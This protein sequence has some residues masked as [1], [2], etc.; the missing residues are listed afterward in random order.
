[1]EKQEDGSRVLLIILPLSDIFKRKKMKRKGGAAMTGKTK[2]FWLLMAVLFS[3]AAIASCLYAFVNGSIFVRPDG[4]PQQTVDRFFDALRAGEYER[5][6]GCLE[7]ASSLGLEQAVEGDSAPVIEALKSSYDYSLLGQCGVDRLS[8]SQKLRFR[9]LDV[10]G[11]NRAID[12]SIDAVLEE[13]AEDLGL[14]EIYDAEGNYLPALTDRVYAEA[15]RRVL[16][17]A[18]D[19]YI[20]R[21]LEC[22][23]TMWTDNGRSVPT[24]SFLT[25]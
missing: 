7:D 11:V 9:F 16:Q 25:P 18:E 19:F 22:S 3:L 17:K 12:E 15:Q 4:D 24:R 21:E 14:D 5:A 6:Y 8:A 20:S 23:S 13:Y 10:R 2:K 1:M